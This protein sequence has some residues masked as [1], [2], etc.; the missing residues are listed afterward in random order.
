MYRRVDAARHPDLHSGRLPNGNYPSGS[1]PAPPRRLASPCS[2]SRRAPPVQPDARPNGTLH[3]RAGCAGRGARTG[4]RTH[5]AA[6]SPRGAQS[7]R[8]GP[9][10]GA[11]QP[12]RGDQR[13]RDADEPARRCTG[14][15]GTPRHGVPEEGAGHAHRGVPLLPSL[16]TGRNGH[17]DGGRDEHGARGRGARRSALARFARSRPPRVPET[18]LTRDAGIRV[19]LICGAMYPCSNPE[20][21]AAV[22]EAGGIGIV[23][24]MSLVYVHGHDFPAGLALIRSLTAR[25]M[26]MN[27]MIETSSKLY[28]RRMRELGGAVDRGRRCASSSPRSATRA[29]WRSSCTRRV[30]IVYHDVTEE[31]WARKALDSGVDGLDRG[32]QP[33]R[34]TRRRAAGRSR[35]SRCC[36]PWSPGRRGRRRRRRARVRAPAGAGLRRGADGYA[37]HRHRRVPRAP[38]ATR[39]RSSQATGERHRAHRARHRRTA[40]GDQHAVRAAHR[41]SR[42]TARAQDARRAAA[43]STWMRTIYAV[44]SAMRLKQ[45]S[46]HGGSSSDYWQAGKSVDGIQAIESAADIV[47][48]YGAAAGF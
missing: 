1:R 31:K 20:L 46:L 42:G 13:A 2:A 3:R 33:R 37:L 40:R 28:M 17:R 18:A 7:P 8:L 26:G 6:R 22:S 38:R 16:G 14:H 10:R 39:R 32:E 12:R 48:R 47:R 9:R 4:V 29:G 23:Q 15:R 25:P 19:P 35:C 43:P 11:R 27:V 45:A 30:G 44:R 34:R 24:P 41:H 36:D 5:Q 21:V